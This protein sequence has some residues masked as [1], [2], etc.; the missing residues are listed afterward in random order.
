[1]EVL[2]LVGLLV[3]EVVE[4][5]ALEYGKTMQTNLPQSTV[6]LQVLEAVMVVTPKAEP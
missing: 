4:E 2:T 5:V 6:A 3:A 1:L